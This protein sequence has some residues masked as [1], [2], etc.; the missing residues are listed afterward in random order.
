M[1][2]L[3]NSASELSTETAP[4]LA[5]MAAGQPVQWQARMKCHPGQEQEQ[6]SQRA[7]DSRKVAI[8]SPSDK[9]LKP[10]SQVLLDNLMPVLYLNGKQVAE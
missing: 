7:L 4:V 9:Q 10:D 6:G 3:S 5:P 2:L 8:H 1:N